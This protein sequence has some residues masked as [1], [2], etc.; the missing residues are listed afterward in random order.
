[1]NRAITTIPTRIRDALGRFATAILK[2]NT[3]GSSSTLPAPAR[4]SGYVTQ[5]RVARVR[6]KGRPTSARAGWRSA[7]GR[8]PLSCKWM[9]GWQLKGLALAAT[10]APGYHPAAGRCLEHREPRR[11]SRQSSALSEREAGRRTWARSSMAEQ[12]TLNQLVGGSSPPGLTSISRD[13]C[14]RGLPIHPRSVEPPD[15]PDRRRCSACSARCGD[16]AS[17]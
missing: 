14:P 6:G 7:S 5:I 17:G 4:K 1:M 11:P 8:E 9:T 13:R 2:G 16:T 15:A 10:P 12:L 3:T